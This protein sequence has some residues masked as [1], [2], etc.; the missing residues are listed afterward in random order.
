VI[1]KLILKSVSVLLIFVA[2][3]SATQ[4][5]AGARHFTFVY[6][7]VTS[8]PGSLDVENWITWSRTSNP[9]RVDEV[10]FRHEFEF[11]IT[12]KFQASVYVAD[13][14]YAA[15]PEHSGF[16]YSDSA[17]ELIYNLT[18]PVVDPLGLAAYEEIRVGDRVFE[19]E[20]KLIA[21]KD[22]GPL[23]LAYNATLEAVWEGTGWQNRQGELQQALGASYEISQRVSVGIEM[24]HE[25]VFPEWRDN[26]RIRNFFIGP[27]VSFRH[28][29]WFVTMTA[30]AQATN[31]PDEAD[32]QLRTIF[33]IGF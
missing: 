20:S 29:N 1:Q 19:L 10:D 32:F 18:N 15:D 25:F 26:E 5:L 11:G 12:D 30:L 17:L 28:R 13:W 8:P 21:Q 23:I 27:N 3:W 6:E 33:G 2:T 9:R 16:T 14:F 24:L 7:A 4:T 22:I 31:T